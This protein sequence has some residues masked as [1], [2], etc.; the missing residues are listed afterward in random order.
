M[1]NT[2]DINAFDKDRTSSP[3]SFRQCQAIGYKFAKKGSSMNWKLQK[4]ITGC[5]YN[6]AKEERLTFKKA[7]TLLQGKSL[8]KVY[9]DVID[10]YLKEK[11]S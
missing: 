9:F 2:F 10:K 3:A 11:V 5:L 8:P 4:Q 1:E 6:L 7:H